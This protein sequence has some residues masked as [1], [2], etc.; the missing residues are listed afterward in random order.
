MAVLNNSRGLLLVAALAAIAFLIF[1]AQG[2]AAGSE[3]PDIGFVKV[4]VSDDPVN[5][6]IPATKFAVSWN[7][8]DGCDET[9][10]IKL[11]D[12]SGEA[13]IGTASFP[14]ES[15][16]KQIKH[17][18]IASGTGYTLSVSCP[19]DTDGED[20]W[21]LSIRLQEETNYPKRGIFTTEPAMTAMSLSSGDLTPAFHRRGLTYTH[22][23]KGYGPFITLDTTLEPGYSVEVVDGR[24]AHA[25]R[26]CGG[27][28]CGEA[29]YSDSDMN[30]LSRLTDADLM[31]DGFQ[32]AVHRAASTITLFVTP[33]YANGRMYFVELVPAVPVKAEFSDVPNSHD[34]S[35][36]ITIT[37]TFSEAPTI[38]FRTL[39]DH[40]FEVTNGEIQTRLYA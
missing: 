9:L 40:A 34:G 33:E 37:L 35:S 5:S 28:T 25:I 6:Q 3:D 18:D 31:T 22:S 20:D 16:E 17:S 38:S 7:H 19:G 2:I 36:F 11:K 32:L 29:S 4:V 8:P 21:Y 1:G 27:S 15:F 14:D 30:T 39:R 12:L 26:T 10:A 24:V 23:I 13:E